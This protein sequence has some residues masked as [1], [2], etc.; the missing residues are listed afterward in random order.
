MDRICGHCGYDY[1]CHQLCTAL[2]GPQGQMERI[3]K[4]IESKVSWSLLILATIAVTLFLYLT[5][6]FGH[7]WFISFRYAIFQVVSALTT[8]GLQTSSGTEITNLY[9]G[10]GIFILTL[11]MIIGAGS[12]STGG[13]IK[14]IRIGIMFKSIWWEIKSLL[15][16]PS[17]KISHKIHHVK[18]LSLNSEILR[19]TGLFVFVYLVVYLLSVIIIAFIYH[20]TS[21]VLFEVASGVGNVGLTAGL[22][23]TTSPALAKIV[24][25]VDMWVGRLEIWPVLIFLALIIRKMVNK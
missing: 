4:D 21:Q 22:I 24:F 20:N 16:P 13:G 18:D 5:P 10:V 8:T 3:F 7:D 12:S 14:W 1:W 11:L 2:H 25:I 17:A 9:A 23:T 15:L 19:L 6:Y